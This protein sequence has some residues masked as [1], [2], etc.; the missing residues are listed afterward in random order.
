MFL[1]IHIVPVAS[2]ESFRSSRLSKLKNFQGG[3]SEVKDCFV[4]SLVENKMITYSSR[5]QF[6]EF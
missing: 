4:S 2:L 6:G 5:R 3:Q 1:N